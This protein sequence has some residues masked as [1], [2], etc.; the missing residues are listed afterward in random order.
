MSEWILSESENQRLF[1]ERVRPAL[2]PAEPADA[3]ALVFAVGQ[4]GAS[5][6]RVSSRLI[7]GTNLAALGNTDLRAFH[8][9]YL[10]LSGSRASEAASVLNKSTSGWM[11]SALQ[12]AR[13]TKRSLLLDGTRSSADV[14]LATMGM[15]ERN[16]FTTTLAVVA[17]SRAESLL[18][19]AS[20]YL[21]ESRARRLANFT[22]VDDHDAAFEAVRTLV[23]TVEASPSVDRMVILGRDGSTRFDAIR[24]D[25]EAFDGARAALENE[26]NAPLAAPQAM[27]WLS[28]LRSMC[29]YALASRQVARPVADVLIELHEIG[30]NEVLPGLPLPD[31][32]QARP[33]AEANLRGQMVALRQATQ[34]ARRPDAPTRPVLTPPSPERGIS[35]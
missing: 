20:H 28:E 3:P 30:L 31:D 23:Q 26:L 18:A 10:E 13:T 5:A 7:D 21:L 9:R 8:P 34:V 6:L 14:A 4:P 29:D 27:R 1:D 11:R 35:R 16:G 22:T 12:H 17:V 19:T 25:S 32:S 33:V 24:D 2:F 15:F